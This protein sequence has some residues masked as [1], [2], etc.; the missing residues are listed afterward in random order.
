[1]AIVEWRKEGWA[2]IVDDSIKYE[3]EKTKSLSDGFKTIKYEESPFDNSFIINGVKYDKSDLM[4][5]E[6][7]IKAIMKMKGKPTVISKKDEKIT[8]KTYDSV[9]KDDFERVPWQIRS[10]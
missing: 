8:E 4:T 10:N 1:M 2:K 3:F 5:N 9:K 7:L 6:D